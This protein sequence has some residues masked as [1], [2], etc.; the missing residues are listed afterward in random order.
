MDPAIRFSQNLGIALEDSGG[1]HRLIGKLIY[2]IVTCPNIIFL[3]A[4]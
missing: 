3:L 2:L 4:C 1:Y